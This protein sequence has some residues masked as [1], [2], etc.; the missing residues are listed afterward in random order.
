MQLCLKPLT[1]KISE[2]IIP[3]LPI[4][5]DARCT[6]FCTPIYA[7]PILKH[8][9]SH[10]RLP[11]EP[12][13]QQLPHGGLQLHAGQHVL[14]AMQPPWVPCRSR[15]SSGSGGS[16]AACCRCSHQQ[17][18]ASGAGVTHGG[19]HG[20]TRQRTATACVVQLRMHILMCICMWWRVCM[21]L[22]AKVGVGWEEALADL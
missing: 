3:R 2:L 17:R 14:A 13:L 4:S 8:P 5:Q 21:W 18:A 9:M 15:S 20:P 22:C 1:C 6:H 7:H 16:T 10:S 11:S 19:M 12:H